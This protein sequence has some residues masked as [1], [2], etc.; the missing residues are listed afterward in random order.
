MQHI[1]RRKNDLPGFGEDGGS[2]AMPRCN[3]CLARVRPPPD[4]CRFIFFRDENGEAAL[5][6]LERGFSLKL[7]LKVR[8]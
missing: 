6:P 5:E 2:L 3:F 8:N 4:A 1:L 7:A